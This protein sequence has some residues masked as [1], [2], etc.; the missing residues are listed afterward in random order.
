MIR[1][2]VSFRGSTVNATQ[3]EGRLGREREEEGVGRETPTVV[4]KS[5][6]SCSNGS[7]SSL[8]PCS[9]LCPCSAT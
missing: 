1:P 3:V 6:S 4:T 9:V 8:S 7:K 2:N 5:L